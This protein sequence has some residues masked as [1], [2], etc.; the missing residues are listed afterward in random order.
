VKRGNS[1]G[2]NLWKKG[3]KE[4]TGGRWQVESKRELKRPTEVVTTNMTKN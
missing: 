2:G 4:V 1:L 3:T